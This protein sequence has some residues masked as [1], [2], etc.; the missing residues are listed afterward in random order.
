RGPL[1]GWAEA[2]LYDDSLML[3]VPLSRERVRNLWQQYISGRREAH[4]LLWSVLMLL[5]FVQK[6][7]ANQSLRAASYRE[8]A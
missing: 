2:L 1:R 7:K 5:F 4:P 8:V 3:R 6:Y